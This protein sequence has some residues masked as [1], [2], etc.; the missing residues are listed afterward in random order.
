[1][2]NQ[3]LDQSEPEVLQDL[4][5]SVGFKEFLRTIVAPYVRDIRK[6]LLAG[7]TDRLAGYAALRDVLTHL[8]KRAGY[9]GDT[10]KRMFE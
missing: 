4:Y 10:I 5:N 1:M 9:E 6:E 3:A 8:Y 2:A 7:R